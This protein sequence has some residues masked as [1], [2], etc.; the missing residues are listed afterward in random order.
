L[1]RPIANETGLAGNFDLSLKW[2]P[3][4]A[5][6]SSNGPSLFAA[7]EEQLGLRLESRKGPAEV[8]VIDS[9]ARPD[10]N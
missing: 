9:A 8:M 1:N 5:T 6:D 4:D 2:A 7:L 3:D 10:A